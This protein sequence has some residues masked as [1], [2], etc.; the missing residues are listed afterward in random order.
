MN[1]T[2]LDVFTI[3]I[4]YTK[5]PSRLQT[6]SFLFNSKVNIRSHFRICCHL[7]DPIL[8]YSIPELIPNPYFY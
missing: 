5:V 1:I 8:T 4:A 2:E 3:F 6:I 7:T